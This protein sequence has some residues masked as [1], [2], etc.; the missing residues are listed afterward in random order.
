M[1]IVS[2]TRF[3]TAIFWGKPRQAK[4]KKESAGNAH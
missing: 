2:A 3:G 4:S 1:D